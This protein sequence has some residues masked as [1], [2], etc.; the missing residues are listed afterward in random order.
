MKKHKH[1]TTQLRFQFG[2]GQ[3]SI[4]SKVRCFLGIHKWFIGGFFDDDHGGKIQEVCAD[5]GSERVTDA[6]AP[7]KPNSFRCSLGIHKF[8][9]TD[10]IQ[11]GNPKMYDVKCQR[12]G[13]VTKKDIN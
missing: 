3:P 13:L 2:L 12:C 7:S 9:V 6:D 10:Q 8:E 4:L 5:C 1:D 11:G